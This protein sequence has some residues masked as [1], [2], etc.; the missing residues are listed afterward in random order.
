MHRLALPIVALGVVA[1]AFHPALV[2]GADNG[3]AS[4]APTVAPTTREAANAERLK[5][6]V[7][8]LGLVEKLKDAEQKLDEAQVRINEAR[9]QAL[10]MKDNAKMAQ[11]LEKLDVAQERINTARKSLKATKAK[12]GL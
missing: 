7:E 10:K 8:R 12:I 5:K 11:M 2:A 3:G 6:E 4:T 9:S 1:T